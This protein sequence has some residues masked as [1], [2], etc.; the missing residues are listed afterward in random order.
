MPGLREESYDDLV[1]DIHLA[2]DH[3]GHLLNAD[4]FSFLV[5]VVVLVALQVAPSNWEDRIG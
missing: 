4:Q 3:P 1:P 2:V 5:V